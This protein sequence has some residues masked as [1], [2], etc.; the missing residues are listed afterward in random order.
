ML[1][2]QGYTI[3]A[4]SNVENV[5]KE[6]IGQFNINYICKNG[7]KKVQAMVDPP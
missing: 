3:V 1:C 4:T 2:H 6:V 7:V 5:M